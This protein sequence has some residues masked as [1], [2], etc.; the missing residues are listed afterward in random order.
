MK[1]LF[2][3]IVLFGGLSLMVASNCYANPI[4]VRGTVCNQK[5]ESLP[6]VSIQVLGQAK[7]TITDIDGNFTLEGTSENDKLLISYIGFQKREMTVKEFMKIILQEDVQ[8]LGEVVITTQKRKQTSI[9]VPVAVSALTGQNLQR[10]NLRQMDDMAQFIPGLQIQIQSP[11]NPGYVIRGVTSDGGESYSQPRISAFMDGVSISRSRAS[12]IELFDMERV[13]VV[14]GPQGTLFGRGAEIGAIHFI[15]N[16]PVNK[17]GGEISIDYGTH[18]QRGASGFINTPISEK[19]SNRLAFAYDAHDGFIKNMS[20]G[21]LNGKSAIALRNSTRLFAGDKT[22]LDL[23]LDYQHDNYPGTSFK[24][25]RIAPIGGDTRPWTDA[26]LNRGN[27][28]GIKRDVGGASF[29]LNHTFNDKLSL[30]SIT[31]LRLFQSDEKFDAD[32]TY[33]SLLNCREQ[34]EG[35]QFSQEFRLNFKPTNWLSGFVGAN[36][37]YE[38]SSQNVS[39]DVNMQQLYPAYIQDLFSKQIIPMTSLLPQIGKLLGL[40][41]IS[42]DMLQ[43]QMEV[44]TNKWF[45][46]R[47]G[48]ETVTNL[49]D[50]YGDLNQLLKQVSGGLISMDMLKSALNS[51]A[52]DELLAGVG[53]SKDVLVRGLNMLQGASDAPL[54]TSYKEQATNYGKN[55]AAEVFADA[56]FKL[57]K[58]LSLTAGIRGTHEHQRTGYASAT[59]PHTIFGSLLYAPSKETV[60]TSDNYYSW[61][62]RVALNYMYKNNNLYASVSKGRRPGVISYNNNPNQISNLKPEIIVSYEAGIKGSILNRSLLYDLSI[63]YYDWNHFQTTRLADNETS[64]SQIY[65]ADDAGR[66]HSFGIEAGLRYNFTR[67]LSVF[68]NY[69]YID[70]KFNEKDNDGHEQEYAGNRFRLT[71]K[72]SFA[73]G[74]DLTLP[75]KSDKQIFVRP[76]YSYKS[77]VYFEDDNNPDL[78][79]KGYGLAN[80]VAGIH[81]PSKNM[82]YEVSAY[83]KNVFNT[84]YTVDAGNTG[85]LIGFPTFVAGSPSVFGIQIKLGF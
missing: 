60:Y 72:H 56:T 75:L 52:Y 27:E 24:S 78:A 10:M 1:V 63:Y 67:N 45:P 48:T 59:D 81:I 30:S 20:G 25:K 38:N 73:I 53:L 18:N 39:A 3:K 16:K 79:Q 76:S 34:A 44:L 50:I 12:V 11:N 55:Q 28:L 6:G 40:P 80:F 19:L 26:D 17:L 36:Y 46:Q 4:D 14:K 35:S 69:S 2:K 22:I 47:S 41:T 85:Y 71:P 65:Q 62:G 64:L 21:R 84:K 31:G 9:E 33:L 58:G 57:C 32:G 5:G 15:R 77:K 37:F 68:S 8:S 42:V 66:A 61:V 13:E 7:G 54:E 29:L 82:Y 51:G 49:P 70:G 43:Q 83:G 23:V 74:M